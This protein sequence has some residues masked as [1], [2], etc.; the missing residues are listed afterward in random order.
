ML[1]RRTP[2]RRSGKPLRRT[3]LRRVSK[4]RAAEL[5]VYSTRRKI[6]L[7]EHPVCEVWC[8]ENGF[9]WRRPGWYAR[10]VAGSVEVNADVLFNNY[11]A[12]R[13]TQVHHKNK[14]R[15]AMLLDEKFWLPVSPHNHERIENNKAWARRHG[16]LLNF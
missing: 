6:F 2:L 8:A 11:A 1:A 9:A 5:R 7:A 15:R 10:P 3:P 16:F 12:P 13:A 14:R 4:T